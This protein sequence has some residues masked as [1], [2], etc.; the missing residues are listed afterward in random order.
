[1][2]HLISLPCHCGVIIVHAIDIHVVSTLLRWRLTWTC[3][4]CG[5]VEGACDTH[6]AALILLHHE[7]TAGEFATELGQVDELVAVLHTEGSDR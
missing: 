5:R 1:M 3:E 7:Q 4:D 6:T 2:S